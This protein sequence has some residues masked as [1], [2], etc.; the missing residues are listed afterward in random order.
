M[1]NQNKTVKIEL[2]TSRVQIWNPDI[3]MGLVSLK[4]AKEMV[5]TGNWRAFTDQ[6]I[7]WVGP[8]KGAN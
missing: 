4:E 2:T 8:Q 6:S 5:A 1:Q 7:M 3:M